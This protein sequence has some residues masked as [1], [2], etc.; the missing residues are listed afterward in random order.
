[1]AL[2]HSAHLDF[3]F[4]ALCIYTECIKAFVLSFTTNVK[5]RKISVERVPEQ[6][7][8][9][10]EWI[11]AFVLSFTATVKPHKISVER[12]P[13]QCSVIPADHLILLVA[14]LVSSV[15]DNRYY[16][17]ILYFHWCHVSQAPAFSAS[18]E[19]QACP[20]AAQS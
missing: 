14:A 10:P 16:Q 1:M 3:M 19:V 15:A 12:V 9:I 6:C 8:V 11:K 4:F 5:P 18:H 13:E 7:S 17:Q 20:K 2:T